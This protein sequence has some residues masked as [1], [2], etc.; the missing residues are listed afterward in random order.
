MENVENVIV[1]EDK[2]KK[3]W[4][5]AALICSIVAFFLNPLSLLAPASMVF[6]IV[7]LAKNQGKGMGIAGLI[8]GFCAMT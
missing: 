5:L 8:V 1:V 3:G 2:P 6:G 7:A 4:G